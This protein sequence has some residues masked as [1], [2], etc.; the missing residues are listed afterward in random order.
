MTTRFA[1]ALLLAVAVLATSMPRAATSAELV[2]FESATCAWCKLWHAQ[3]GPIYPKTDEAKC[4]PLRRVDIHAPRPDDL[5]DIKGVVFTP[6][7]VVVDGG[8]EVS[9]LV[10]YAGEEFFWSLLAEKLA[11]LGDRC[12]F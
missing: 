3:I 8:K 1:Q 4:A 6:T 10:G 2:M 11:P 12:K 7:F 9:R 5:V